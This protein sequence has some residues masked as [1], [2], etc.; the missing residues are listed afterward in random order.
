[1]HNIGSFDAFVASSHE[2][3]KYKRF[4]NKTFLLW[5]KKAFHDSEWTVM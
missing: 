3:H 4:G 2:Y 1:M 5:I